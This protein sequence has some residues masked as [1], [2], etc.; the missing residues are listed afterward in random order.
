MV[1]QPL[2]RTGTGGAPPR[3]T[4]NSNILRAC[5]RPGARTFHTRRISSRLSLAGPY[6]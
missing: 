4:V 3:F 1:Y 5:W 2:L 6:A